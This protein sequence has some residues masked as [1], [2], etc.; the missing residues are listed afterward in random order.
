MQFSAKEPISTQDN[1]GKKTF[2]LKNKR[3]IRSIK[4][5]KFKT[6][7]RK[8][9]SYKR[10]KKCSDAALNNKNEFFYRKATNKLLSENFPAFMET[11]QNPCIQLHQSQ[12]PHY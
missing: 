3:L 6:H 4:K 5:H 12:F 10:I 1:I 2:Y 11:M 7:L 9:I 8:K